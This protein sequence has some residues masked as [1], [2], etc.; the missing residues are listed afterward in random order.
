MRLLKIL[1]I[2]ASAQ[3]RNVPVAQRVLE[4]ESSVAVAGLTEAIKKGKE[5]W[6]HPQKFYLIRSKIH[7][8]I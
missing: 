7:Q 8:F 3:T 4:D 1:G 6:E 2:M 5:F